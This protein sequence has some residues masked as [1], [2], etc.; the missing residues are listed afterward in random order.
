MTGKDNDVNILYN[1]HHEDTYDFENVE[2]ENHTN[3][4]A[5]IRELDD[6]HHWVQAGEGWP[7]ETLHHIECELQRLLIAL[8]LSAPPE[9]LNNV[10]KQYMDN[11][12]SA[13]KQTN[14]RNTLIQDISIFNGNDSTQLE[15]SLVDIETAADLSA[16]SKTKLGQAKSKGLTH[17]LIAEALNLGKCLNDIKDILHLKTRGKVQMSYAWS[18][19]LSNHEP[20]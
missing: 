2:Q 7:T 3:L 16:E 18:L 15:D 4:E 14:F 19:K 9:P 20:S 17:T 12:C 1:Y 10:L 13:Q 5:L 6:L 8:C 11:L